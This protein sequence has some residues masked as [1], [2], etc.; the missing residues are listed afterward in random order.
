MITQVNGDSNFNVTTFSHDFNGQYSKAFIQF[1]SNGQPG[2]V[3]FQIRYYGSKYNNNRLV[4]NFY[5]SVIAGKQNTHFN[6]NLLSVNST[7]YSGTILYFE[8]INMNS[9][10]I[11]VLAGPTDPKGAATKGYVDNENARQDI[12]INNLSSRK[13]NKT[14]VDDEISKIDLSDYLKVNGSRAMTGNLGIGGNKITDLDT[15]D[16][17]SI[18]DYPN[19]L[20]DA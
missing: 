15:Q 19:Y 20:K 16:D 1:S 7:D 18:A 10:K 17:V 5:S 4:F 13:A 14:Y 8:P 12:A 6:H 11:V 9:Q 2:E 3:T